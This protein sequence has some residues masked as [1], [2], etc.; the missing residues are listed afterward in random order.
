VWKLTED[1]AMTEA[2][3]IAAIIGSYRPGGITELAL[4]ELLAAAEAAGASVTR[5][6]LRERHVEFCTNCRHCT[7]QP[8]PERGSCPL[9]DDLNSIL[10]TI[11]Q[12]DAIVL[13]SPVNFGT[14]TALMKRFMERLVCFAYWPWGA[15]APKVRSNA[16]TKPAVIIIASA[17][18]ALMARYLTGTVRLLAKT[19]GLLGAR[20]IGVLAIGFAALRQEPHLS[21]RTR[22]KARRLGRLLAG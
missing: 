6:D 14:V 15:A 17:A 18:P 19:A 13:V 12:A 4:A 22:N 2:K 8:G 1:K 9:D 7:S 3:N 5:I 16:T 11:R 21:E 20:P 10:E